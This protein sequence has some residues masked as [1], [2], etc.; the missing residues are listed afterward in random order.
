[1]NLT[2]I[3]LGGSRYQDLESDACKQ[4]L[5]AAQEIDDYRFGVSSDAD[6]IS[7]YGVDGDAVLVLKKVSRTISNMISNL[8][9]FH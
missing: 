9:Q 3:F 6:V 2:F 1:M 8:V 7:E 4:F 5:A